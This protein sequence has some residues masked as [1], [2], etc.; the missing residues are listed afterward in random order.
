MREVVVRAR[1]LFEFLLAIPLFILLIVIDPE[2]YARTLGDSE[3]SIRRRV[4]RYR[5]AALRLPWNPLA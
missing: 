4:L 1:L 2:Y 3:R 5:K